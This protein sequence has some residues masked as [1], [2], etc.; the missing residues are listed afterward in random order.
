MELFALDLGNRQVKMKSSRKVKVFPSYF[1]ESSKFGDRATMQMRKTRKRTNDYTSS[2]DDLFTYVWGKD[3][4]VDIAKPVDSI[5]FTDRYNSREFKLL[6][7]FALAEM[8]K[9]FPESKESMLEVAVVTGVPTSDYMQEKVVEQIVKAM[10]G[11]HAVTIDGLPLAIRV[12][13]VTV[14]PQPMGTIVD[15]MMTDDGEIIEDNPIENAVVGI[16]DIGGGT[17]L[18]DL[19]RKMNMDTDKRLQSSSG[20]YTLYESIVRE[21]ARIG[22]NISVYE[23]EQ[24]LRNAKTN[25][26]YWSPDGKETLDISDIVMKE[27]ILFTREIASMIKSVFKEFDRMAA[28]LITG[29]AANL[30]VKT[31][32]SQAVPK[33]LFV[34]DSEKANVNGFYKYGLWQGVVK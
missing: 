32:F 9:D 8:A 11:D 24:T 5:G 16:A 26:Y 28:V 31:E 1:I 2:K 12:K 6:V 10:K 15:A 25:K 22:R 34:N 27:R 33:A 4:D 18:V 29:G 19:L 30:L 17:L 14:L 20:A 3:L 23:V 21:L 13:T 7:D